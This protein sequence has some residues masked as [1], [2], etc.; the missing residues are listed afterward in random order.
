MLAA[1]NSLRK[2]PKPVPRAP[3]CPLA[4]TGDKAYFGEGLSAK[5]RHTVVETMRFKS[6][7]DPLW[8]QQGNALHSGRN[9]M[10]EL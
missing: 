10:Q 7:A 1:E 6:Q 9:H 5:K 2:A 8:S 3:L 4:V